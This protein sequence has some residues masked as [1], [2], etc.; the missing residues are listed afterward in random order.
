MCFIDCRFYITFVNSEGSVSIDSY[1]LNIVAKSNR[2]I[3]FVFILSILKLIVGY[4]I[5]D[6]V[7]LFDQNKCH[8]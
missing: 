3:V 2:K 8:G 1:G 5:Y 6:M 7:K 4:T